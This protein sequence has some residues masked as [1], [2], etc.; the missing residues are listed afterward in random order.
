[1]MNS[2]T[3]V[4]VPN[5]WGRG[6]SLSEAW[7]AVEAESGQTRAFHERGRKGKGGTFAVFV[8]VGEGADLSYC[9]PV[10]GGLCYPKGCAAYLIENR[11]A[12]ASVLIEEGDRS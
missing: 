8:V 1:M 12:G 2:A 10:H 7:R 9:E 11:R 6:S 3:V 5:Y 4:V